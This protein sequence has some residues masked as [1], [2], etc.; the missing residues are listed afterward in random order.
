[1]GKAVETPIAQSRYRGLRLT[2]TQLPN[3]G[4][5]LV[6]VAVKAERA[7][8]DDWNLL[9]PAVRLEPQALDSHMAVL[10]CLQGVI[11]HLLA[12]GQ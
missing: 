12:D 2:V 3:D 6:G 1:M 8:W 5:L 7:H 9:Y 4:A 11:Q 10:E